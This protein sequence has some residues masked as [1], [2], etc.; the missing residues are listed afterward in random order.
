M[1]FYRR[2]TYLH[3]SAVSAGT[4]AIRRFF[5]LDIGVR[6]LLSWRHFE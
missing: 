6:G 2:L 1:M 5:A 4:G 3:D